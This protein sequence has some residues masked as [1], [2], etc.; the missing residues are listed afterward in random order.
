MEV[1]ASNRCRRT[2]HR[3]SL[4][5]YRSRRATPYLYSDDELAALLAAAGGLPHPLRADTCQT[6]I[7]LLAVTGIRIGEAISLDLDDLDSEHGLLVVREGKFGKTRQLPLHTS[8][9][10]ALAGYLQRCQRLGSAVSD[11]ARGPRSAALFLSG[12]GS[13]VRHCNISARSTS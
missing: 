8:T 3:W 13:H 9:V 10:A 6:M 12:R 5:S 7:A 11:S 2:A 4:L 1:R